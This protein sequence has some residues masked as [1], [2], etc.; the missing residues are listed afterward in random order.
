M[1]VHSVWHVVIAKAIRNIM[2]A[3]P[4]WLTLVALRLPFC[5]GQCQKGLALVWR[6]VLPAAM[7]NRVVEDIKAQS[8]KDLFKPSV[9]LPSINDQLPVNPLHAILHFKEK[10]ACGQP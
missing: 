3:A 10:D 8:H 7:A 1:F 4:L 6:C 5:L 9:P 2:C